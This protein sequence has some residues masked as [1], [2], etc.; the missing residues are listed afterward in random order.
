MPTK[1]GVSGALFIVIPNVGGMSVFAP[2]LDRLGNSVKGVDFCREL[3][4]KFPFHQFDSLMALE[5]KWNPISKQDQLADPTLV[6]FYYS[7]YRGDLINL[8]RSIF[9]GVKPMVN[10]S[11]TRYHMF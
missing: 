7:A 3:V 10:N 1:S 4:K 2:P 8:R 6:D 9:N 5:E 11:N